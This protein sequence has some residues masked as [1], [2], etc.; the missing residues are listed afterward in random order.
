MSKEKVGE[1][2]G[3]QSSRSSRSSRS[4]KASNKRD[5]SD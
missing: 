1:G 3:R 5:F 2:K 4:S